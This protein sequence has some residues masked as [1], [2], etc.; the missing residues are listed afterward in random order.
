MNQ[1][2]FDSAGATGSMYVASLELGVPDWGE[3]S[4]LRSILASSYLG[5]LSCGLARLVSSRVQEV[6]RASI[7]A[8]H[9]GLHWPLAGVTQLSGLL[10][11]YRNF[12]EL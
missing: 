9:L 2:I 3:F 7:M 8:P 10:W 11:L 1:S 12:R 4:I 5:K 6:E